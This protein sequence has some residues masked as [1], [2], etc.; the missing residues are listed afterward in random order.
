M[1]Q[2]FSWKIWMKEPW[3]KERK[4]RD[5]LW[6][7]L[8]FCFLVLKIR[9]VFLSVL[10]W[11]AWCWSYLW[12]VVLIKELFANKIQ[13]Y[14]TIISLDYL[15]DAY[16]RVGYNHFLSN[17]PEKNNCFIKISRINKFSMLILWGFSKRFLWAVLYVLLASFLTRTFHVKVS[18]CTN[19][20]LVPGDSNKMVEIW[21]P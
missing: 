7:K 12:L 4:W 21:F 2:K 13:G 17:K 5:L 11:Y 19:W 16:C 10:F 3:K 20:K 18:R 1:Q 15:R 9:E 14:L 6:T 8:L